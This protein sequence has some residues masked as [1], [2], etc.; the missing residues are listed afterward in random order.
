MGLILP[1]LLMFTLG[2]IEYG[3]YLWAYTTLMRATEAAA[4]CG[5]RV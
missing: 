4:R 3:R 1:A 5:A 2:I